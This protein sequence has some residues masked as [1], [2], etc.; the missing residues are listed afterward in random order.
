[1]IRE[2]I[3]SSSDVYSRIFGD[4]YLSV[5]E[6][7]LSEKFEKK[8]ILISS[9][10]FFLDAFKV[11]GVGYGDEVI[12]PALCQRENVRAIRKIGGSPVF[13]DIRLSDYA[14]DSDR[15]EEAITDRTK[16]IL[17][18]HLFGNPAIDT[19]KILRIAKKNSLKV[20][21][22]ISGAFGAK[23]LIDG[24]WRNVGTL[25]D[26]GYFNFSQVFSDKSL[27]MS[28][29]IC[30]KE[31]RIYEQLYGACVTRGRNNLSFGELTR[32]GRK[33]ARAEQDREQ[34]RFIITRYES[35][36]GGVS[37]IN[38]QRISG[39]GRSAFTRYIFRTT[40]KEEIE[41]LLVNLDLRYA[42][43]KRFFLPSYRNGYLS[44]SFPVAEQ[45]VRE[46]ILLP[47]S[48]KYASKEAESI[49]EAVKL[50]MKN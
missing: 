47:V 10:E 17:I 36:L 49:I 12:L 11:L 1:M 2:E 43:L 8:G 50:F 48:G 26:I 29:M 19:E 37:E 14:I 30:E 25:G 16:L 34:R 9:P 31:D 13:V 27:L 46:S 21:E 35:A 44:G 4:P 42:N 38:L 45:A 39:G 24:R 7:A 3:T 41:R 28:G 33:C 20:L 23:L 5:F 32:V 6:S 22:N 18:S 15:I 40:K